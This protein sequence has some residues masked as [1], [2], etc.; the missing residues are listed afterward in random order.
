[1]MSQ[2]HSRIRVVIAVIAIVCGDVRHAEACAVCFGDPNS[3]LTKGALWGVAVMAGVIGSVLACIAGTGL[4]WIH[5]S[6]KLRA[7]DITED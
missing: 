7:T 3:P 4:Y 2:R 6:R 5:R 1:M